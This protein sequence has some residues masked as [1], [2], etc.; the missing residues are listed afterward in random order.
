MKNLAFCFVCFVICASCSDQLKVEHFNDGSFE[1]YSINESGQKCGM[2][3]LYSSSGVLLY[4]TT[5][6]DG[7]INGK[8]YEF[9]SF[10]NILKTAIYKDG[11][12]DY[13]FDYKN[14]TTVNEYRRFIVESPDT[15]KLGDK[16]TVRW[17]LFDSVH[18]VNNSYMYFHNA[19]GFVV[20]G[21]VNFLPG[22]IISES[23]NGYAEYSYLP[24]KVG[25]YGFYIGAYIENDEEMKMYEFK[26]TII[27]VRELEYIETTYET[28]TFNVQGKRYKKN[29][30][31]NKYYPVEPDLPK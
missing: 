5:Y 25:M 20:D 15:I 11:Y 6:K 23:I 14:D 31:T 2:Y 24:K 29:N 9:D 17:L 12:S 10:G 8:T 22:Y 16:Y 26:R 7:V 3:E 19:P 27:V 21:A 1:K 4:K 13:I 18:S 28:E 30:N